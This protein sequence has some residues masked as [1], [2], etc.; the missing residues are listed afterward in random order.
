MH[1]L[2]GRKQEQGLPRLGNSVVWR[3]SS[4]GSQRVV[5]ALGTS[6]QGHQQFQ[7]RGGPGERPEH[8]HSSLGCLVFALVLDLVFVLV[9]I[10]R[11]RK[12]T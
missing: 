8:Q 9:L 10:V 4:R 5:V 2:S 6:D 12:C 7:D 11:S 1:S 3:M